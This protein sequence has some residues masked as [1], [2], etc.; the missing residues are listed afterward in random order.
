MFGHFSSGSDTGTSFRHGVVSPPAALKISLLGKPNRP[1]RR[2]RNV[3]FAG[4]GKLG[5]SVMK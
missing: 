4:T 3:S 5:V 1:G 2:K